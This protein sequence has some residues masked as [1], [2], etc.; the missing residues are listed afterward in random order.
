MTVSRAQS[1]AL[2]ELRGLPE[3]VHMMLMMGQRTEAGELLQGTEETFAELVSFIAEDLAEG[4]VSGRS[5]PPLRALCSKSTRTARTGWAPEE[6]LHGD[7][8]R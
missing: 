5:I 2:N 6:G 7:D 8:A 4:M 3:K 1:L